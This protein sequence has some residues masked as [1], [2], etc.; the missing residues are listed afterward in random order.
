MIVFSVLAGTVNIVLVTLAPRYAVAVLG[1][2]PTN[3]AYVFAPSAIGVGAALVLAP[4]A[5]RKVGERVVSM[6]ALFVA[7]L[8][9]FL[10]GAI[11]DGLQH[12]RSGQS[13]ARGR[14]AADST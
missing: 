5:I 13:A 9:L 8:S 7:A 1:T 14:P 3:T 12:R 11:G 2:D 10:L 6:S 4:F